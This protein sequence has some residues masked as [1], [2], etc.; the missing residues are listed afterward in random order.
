MA[1][2]VGGSVGAVPDPSVNGGGFHW[3]GCGLTLLCP[4][5]QKHVKAFSQHLSQTCHD[6]GHEPAQSADEEVQE[7]GQGHSCKYQFPPPT[8]AVP[9]GQWSLVGRS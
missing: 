2:A 8:C 3:C 4:E 6:A 9:F 5:P 7:Q 1:Q